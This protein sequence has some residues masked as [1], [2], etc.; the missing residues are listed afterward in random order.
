MFDKLRYFYLFLSLVHHMKSLRIPK[1]T[2]KPEKEKE[3]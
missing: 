1:S 2:Q 3:Q